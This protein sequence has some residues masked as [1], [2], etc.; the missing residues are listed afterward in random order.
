MGVE[1]D[2]PDHLGVGTVENGEREADASGEAVGVTA[3]VCKIL[4][5]GH[6]AARGQLP[7]RKRGLARMCSMLDIQAT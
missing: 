5:D 1:V 7:S 3:W 4:P 2:A 6:A